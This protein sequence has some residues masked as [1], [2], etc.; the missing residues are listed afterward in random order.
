MTLSLS[1]FKVEFLRGLADN[2]RLKIIESLKGRE[3]TVSQLVEEIGGSQS[4]ISTHLKL[5]K[6][7]GILKSRNEGKYVY[8][9]LRD[10]TICE[11]LNKLEDMLLLMR[12]KALEGV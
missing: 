2:T 11:F 9:S 8:Y 5:L 12:R 4:N 6:T 10:E 1:E 3:R 7:T